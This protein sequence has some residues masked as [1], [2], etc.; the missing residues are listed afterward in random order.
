MADRLLSGRNVAW[1]LAGAVGSVAIVAGAM[2]LVTLRA[3]PGLSG[4]P[5]PVPEAANVPAG[6]TPRYPE[7]ANITQRIEAM[8]ALPGLTP[9][10][11]SVAYL[12]SRGNIDAVN[13]KEAA[14]NPNAARGWFQL[15]PSSG[16]VGDFADFPVEALHDPIAT[17][18]MAADYAQRCMKNHFSKLPSDHRNW[19]ALRRCWASWQYVPDYQELEARSAVVREHMEVSNRAV[20]LPTN[21]MYNRA[22]RGNWPGA[23]EVYARLTGEDV[24]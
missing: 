24:A 14:T 8:G 5:P 11:Q 21:W 2:K 6:W 23:G 20:G 16:L 10:L 7:I 1:G 17:T 15:R 18:V 12:E 13:R 19:L 3:E 22:T 9:F 4:E